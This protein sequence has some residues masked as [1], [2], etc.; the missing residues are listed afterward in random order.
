M[1]GTKTAKAAAG[2]GINLPIAKI[3]PNPWNPRRFPKKADAE[4]KGLTESIRQ[5]GVLEN[6]LVRPMGKGY[7]LLAGERRLRCAKAASLTEVPCTV[8]EM[9]DHQA[10]VIT[11]TE[12]LQRKQL[13]FLEEAEGVAG[14]LE[15]GWTLDMVASELGRPLSWVARRRRLTTLSAKWQKV[16]GDP[17]SFAG[18]WSAAQFEIVAVLETTA[19]DELLARDN[20]DFQR[21]RTAG[22]LARYIGSLTRSLSSFP[23]KLSDALLFPKGCSTTRASLRSRRVRAPATAIAASILRARSGSSRSSSSRSARSSSRSTVR[24]SS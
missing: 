5:H 20:Y 13:H 11:I 1:A 10:R 6:L 14:L 15:E 12:N 4:D 16:A 18:R 22:E 24:S 23:W 8:R 21:C 2:V 19:Q 17:E 9:D 3:E 7:Q